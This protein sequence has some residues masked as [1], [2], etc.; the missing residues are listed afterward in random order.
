MKITTKN[1]IITS[2]MEFCGLVLSVLCVVFFFVGRTMLTYLFGAF[3]ILFIIAFVLFSLVSVQSKRLYDY[4]AI[5]FDFFVSV[6]VCAFMIANIKDDKIQTIVL[7]LAAAIYGGLLTLIG[8]AWTIK[9]SDRDRKEDE[10]K[11]AI[12]LFSFN[13]LYEPPVGEVIKKLCIPEDLELQYTDEVY[14]EFEN[15]NR[16]IAIFDRLFH[17]NAWFKLQG[18]NVMLPDKTCFFSFRHSSPNNIFLVVKDSMGKEYAYHIKVLRI[19]YQE[20]THKI[21]STVREL[22]EISFDEM[23]KSIQKLH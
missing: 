16:S 12:P 13:M 4:L 15:S 22:N 7:S 9:K 10:K 1:Y 17:D 21:F 19:R 2:I 18:N 14:V 3:G 5:G 20:Q 23:N 8:V 11:K 6:V